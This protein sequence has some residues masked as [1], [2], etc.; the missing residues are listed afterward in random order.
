LIDV[1]ITGPQ[2]RF[3]MSDSFSTCPPLQVD[4]TNRSADYVSFTWDFGDG[5]TS[6]LASPIHI[7]TYPGVYLVKLM[8]QGYG[9][10]ADTMKRN[11]TI[12]GPTGIMKYDSLPVCYPDSIA[13]SVN[14]QNTVSYTWDFSDGSAITTLTNKTSHIYD[15][16]VY[17]PQMILA[18]SLGC[19]VLI[20]G[21]DTVKVFDVAA[22][23]VILGNPACDSSLIQFIDASA[24]RDSILH[25]LWFFGDK[26]SADAQIVNH[27]Y[28]NVGSYNV[29]L[30]AITLSG[31]RDTFNVPAPVIILPT[32]EITILGDSSACAA[33]LVNFNGINNVPDTSAITWKWD[34]GNGSSSV[35]KDGST[36]YADAGK[37]IVSLTATN[38]HGCADTVAKLISINAAPR[39]NAGPDTAICQGSAYQ[40]IASGAEI[41][42][43]TG[44]G[45]SCSDCRSPNIN[46][47]TTA[48]YVVT[49][50]DGLGCSA[51]DTVYIR[52][53]EPE[54]IAVIG[55]DTL[56]VGESAQF[57]A[58]GA[59][60]YQWYPSIFLDN[61]K[62]AQPIFKPLRDTAI[63]F[64][65]I[66]YSEKNCF[67]DTGFVF[68]KAYPVPEMDILADE[69]T[70]DAG[71]SVRLNTN[72]SADITQWQWQPQTGLDDPN[73]ANPL[74][75]PKQTTRYACIASNG[76]DCISRDEITVNVV[77]KNT[78]IFIPN[79][80]SPNNDGVNDMFFPRGKGLFSVK[81]FRIFNR[82]GQ[83]IFERFNVSP[84][85]SADG[86][87]GTYNG[88]GLSSDVYVFMIEIICENNATIPIKGNVTLLR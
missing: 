21:K 71:S 15:E 8:T 52:V 63:N 46:I 81:S 3:I 56:C 18:D 69:I 38:T 59:Q 42:F 58:S 26:D 76:G 79:T 57:A 78:N 47:D 85:N 30:I 43:W 5:S 84:N 12:K 68:V 23:G 61:D 83:L 29:K 66:G 10:C 16:G 60:S 13:F 54:E 67:S 49:G 9:S 36:T 28:T 72:S 77:C 45:L 25:H 65:V 19:N 53:I 4:F 7:Y 22:N 74:A 1:K 32:P 35:E 70:L 62:S 40:L 51:S 11:V 33:T 17:V 86:W 88:Q 82:W 55:G 27:M 2:A 48:A 73:S 41:Y 20:K 39:V 44:D 24:S 80:F 75:S 34:F 50:K 31:C 37:Y 87:D 64:R 6:A 14:A